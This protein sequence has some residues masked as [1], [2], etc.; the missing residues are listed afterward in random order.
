M[1]F[2]T[3][4]D[5]PDD[6]AE[7]VAEVPALRKPGSERL[8]HPVTA[9]LVTAVAGT[10]TTAWAAFWLW[11]ELHRWNARFLED[12]TTRFGAAY[13]A[14]WA[15][16]WAPLGGVPL[17]QAVDFG[18][19][20]AGL[21]LLAWLLGARTG[22]GPRRAPALVAA[23]GAVWT[24]AA[25]A[26][27][28]LSQAWP[29]WPGFSVPVGFGDDGL[30]ELAPSVPAF[31]GPVVVVLLSAAAAWLGSRATPATPR[32][33]HRAGSWFAAVGVALG[34]G[35]YVAVIAWA[36]QMTD[37]GPWSATQL[38]EW[39]FVALVLAVLVA[40]AVSGNG[41][42]TSALVALAATM[43][44][45]YAVFRENSDPTRFLLFAL[46]LLTV[47]AAATHRQLGETL[48]RLVV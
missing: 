26:L 46:G 25:F 14:D 19:L 11:L 23:V 40:W 7:P 43:L 28:A 34:L 47:V 6:V 31:A 35:T 13:A 38:V 5:L 45:W 48:H 22:L 32:P 29:A 3:P 12:I 2:A 42:A 4:P 41:K 10:G 36:W 33:R 1:A 27:F 44:L 37:L 16:D 20:A 18:I 8:G 39:P 9:L 30:V 15:A 21:V 24:V 17:R